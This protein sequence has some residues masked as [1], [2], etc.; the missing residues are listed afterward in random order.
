MSVQNS[1][2]FGCIASCY[3]SW[4]RANSVVAAAIAMGIAENGKK[5][6]LADEEWLSVFAYTQPDPPTG[7]SPY[8]AV[9]TAL[10]FPTATDPHNMVYFARVVVNALGKLPTF[11]GPVVR[12]TNIP[13][14]VMQEAQIG[15]FCDAGFLSVSTDPNLHFGKDMIV[16][17]SKSA[18]S[19]KGLSAFADER[20]LLYPPRTPFMVT[21]LVN[22][23]SGAILILHEV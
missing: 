17:V 5:L 13:D 20:E 4:S 3:G 8:R 6:G 23:A 10:R 9:N 12:R 15:R 18:R 1:A 19:L 16:I 14:D 2:I 11:T 21:S 22:E 7:V